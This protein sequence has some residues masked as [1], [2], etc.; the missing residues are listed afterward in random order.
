M[1]PFDGS[2]TL[3]P[4]G[5]QGT[6]KQKRSKPIQNPYDLSTIAFFGLL[7][8]GMFAIVFFSLW[9]RNRSHVKGLGYL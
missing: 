5:N 9:L 2:I 7:F 6:E 8:H 4:F 1:Y 3:T